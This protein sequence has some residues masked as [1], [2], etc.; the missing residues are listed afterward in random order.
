L[1]APAFIRIDSTSS[2]VSGSITS[3]P[4]TFK[5]FLAIPNG[6]AGQVL[7]GVGGVAAAS[8]KREVTRIMVRI[9]VLIILNGSS[10]EK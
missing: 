2:R 9:M 10:K 1:L 7:R 4:R 3:P 8:D 5:A 6:E